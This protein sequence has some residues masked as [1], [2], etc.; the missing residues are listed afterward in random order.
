MKVSAGEAFP[1]KLLLLLWPIVCCPKFLGAFS[2]AT[3]RKYSVPESHTNYSKVEV[4]NSLTCEA[5]IN[6]E[7]RKRLSLQCTKCSMCLSQRKLANGKVCESENVL[8]SQGMTHTHTH[9]HKQ[10]NEHGSLPRHQFWN[11][12]S[13]AIENARTKALRIARTA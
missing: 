9:G 2:S 11:G 8:F 3:M 7:V 4:H 13:P 12:S 6:S 1:Q 10:T 5:K